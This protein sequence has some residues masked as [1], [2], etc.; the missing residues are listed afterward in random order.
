MKEKMEIS[1][2]N[3]LSSARNSN[4]KK[5]L[6]ILDLIS[7]PHEQKRSIRKAILEGFNELYDTCCTVLTY[8]QEDKAKEINGLKNGNKNS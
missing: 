2:T 5:T 4:I 6:D 8:I 1:I 7:I 3:Y